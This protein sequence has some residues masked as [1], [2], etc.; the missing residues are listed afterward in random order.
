MEH[1]TVKILCHHYT[2]ENFEAPLKLLF[3]LWCEV[4]FNTLHVLKSF[5]LETNFQFKKQEKVTQLYLMRMEY[6]ALTQSH[7]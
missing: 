2:S 3:S 5:T 1:Y 7:V 6:A 4:S